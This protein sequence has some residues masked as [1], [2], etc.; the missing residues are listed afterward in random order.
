MK[1]DIFHNAALRLTGLYLIIIMVISLL[2]SFWLYNVSISEIE[3]SVLRAPGPIEEILRRENRRFNQELQLIQSQVVEDAR[4]NLLFQFFVLNCVIAFAGGIGSYYL[5]R[6]TLHPIEEAHNSLVRFTADA[7]HE[8]R[9]PITAMKLETEVT[10]SEPKLTLTQAKKQLESNLEELDSLTSLSERLLSL[11]RLDDVTLE[12]KNQHIKPILMQAITEITPHAEAKKQKITLK[13]TDKKLPIHRDSLFESLV[14]LLD[15]AVKYSPDKT[16]ITVRTRVDE[17]N[18]YIDVIDNGIGIPKSE[19]AKIFDRF[20]RVDDS[21]TKNTVN[22]HG[23]GLSI[24]RSSVEAMGGSLQVKS[25][26]KKG[27]TFTIQ[28]PLN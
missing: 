11:A 25:T 20:Y 28:L 3:H 5:A 22:G 23:I 10:L 2:F 21:R 13:V 9:T 17:G 18:L 4:A 27:S 26:P 19:L 16:A 14:I 8:L 7:S 6:R 24:A 12:K 15:N 1:Q